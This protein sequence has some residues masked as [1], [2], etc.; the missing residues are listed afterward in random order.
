MY[1]IGYTLEA[2]H[3]TTAQQQSHS[4]RLHFAQQAIL[5]IQTTVTVF[6]LSEEKTQKEK[7]ESFCTPVPC[8]SIQLRFRGVLTKT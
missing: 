5:N 8:L 7:E 6:V 1:L 2:I 4:Y 3:L